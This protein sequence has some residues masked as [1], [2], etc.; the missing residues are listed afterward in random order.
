VHDT[1]A[2]TNADPPRA[3]FDEFNP[4]N[5]NIKVY[6]WF[7]PAD[8]WAYLDYTQR[9]NLRLMEEFERAGIEFAFPTRTVMLSSDGKRKPEATMPTDK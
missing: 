6:Y 8:W 7:R 2:S 1:N 3:F 9:F 4:E 5:L